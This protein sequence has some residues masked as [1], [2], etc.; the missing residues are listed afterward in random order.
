MEDQLCEEGTRLHN[1]CLEADKMAY[2]AKT[3]C[4]LAASRYAQRTAA[5]EYR[6]HRWHCKIC[7]PKWEKE[8][9]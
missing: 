9:R 8:K 2:R 5:N 1:A 3:P 7:A 6:K 4:E